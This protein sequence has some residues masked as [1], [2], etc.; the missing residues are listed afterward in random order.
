MAAS[1]RDKVLFQEL[2]DM[3][4]NNGKHMV[5]LMLILAHIRPKIERMIVHLNLGCI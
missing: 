1:D 3:E 5:M 2:L 4:R